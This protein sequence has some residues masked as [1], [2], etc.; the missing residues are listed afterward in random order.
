M[1]LPKLKVP[2]FTLRVPSTQKEI[3][4][5][6]FLVKEEK[7]LLIAVESKSRE[8]IVATTRQVVHNCILSNDTDVS[9]LPFFDVDYLFIALRAKSVGDKVDVKFTCNHVVDKQE[10]GHIFSASIDIGKQAKL[11]NLPEIN[12]IDLGSGVQVLMRYPKYATMQSI[13]DVESLE[14]KIGLIGACIDRII[15]GDE[16]TTNKDFTPEEIKNFI[17][18]LTQGQF[19]KLEHFVDHFPKV[20]LEVEA[21][22][23]ACK[24]NHKLRY[25]DFSSFFF[26]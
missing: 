11:S 26:S 5:R 22:C 21:Q 8:D 14:G 19:E 10:C 13:P 25:D 16:V 15:H 24:F 18:G 4:C 2:T 12:K 20:Y 7:L 17:E 6:P 1:A 3:L 23:P 9:A